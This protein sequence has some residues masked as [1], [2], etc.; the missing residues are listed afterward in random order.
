MIL[1][2]KNDIILKIVNDIHSL[3]LKRNYKDNMEFILSLS[4]LI[5]ELLSDKDLKKK[6]NDLIIRFEDSKIKLEIFGVIRN[7]LV[8]FPIF[9]NW[10]DIYI[11]YDI[12]TWNKP[13]YSKIVNFFNTY[14]GKKISYKIYKKYSGVVENIHEVELTVPN[15]TEGFYLN[16]FITYNDTIDIFH[17]IYYLLKEYGINPD[18]L[19]VFYS[20]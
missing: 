9:K 17:L 20:I 14:N 6:F 3:F 4:S 1:K 2:N 18:E 7:I 19:P 10:E 8:H 15:L 5:D 12:V 13:V 11:N 16:E